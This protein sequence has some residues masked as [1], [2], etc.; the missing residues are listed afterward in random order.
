MAFC[1]PEIMIN[2]NPILGLYRVNVGGLA[3]VSKYCLLLQ[4]L[5]V[6]C[7]NLFKNQWVRNG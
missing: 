3:A 5:R 7:G 6:Y 1:Q 2:G 4:G